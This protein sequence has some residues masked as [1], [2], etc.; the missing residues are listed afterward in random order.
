LPL[1]FIAI[2]YIC[3]TNQ[4]FMTCSHVKIRR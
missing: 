1:N 2:L 4:D 3:V